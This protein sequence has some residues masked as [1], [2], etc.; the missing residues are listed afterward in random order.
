MELSHRRLAARR[1]DILDGLSVAVA[2]LDVMRVEIV[3]ID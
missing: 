1:S 3:P 2:P